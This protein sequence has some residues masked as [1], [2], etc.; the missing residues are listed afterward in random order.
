M[1]AP[2]VIVA[3]LMTALLLGGCAT[4]RAERRSPQPASELQP[5]VLALF[6]QAQVVLEER[7]TLGEPDD[8]ADRAAAL[9]EQAITLEPDSATL[10]RYLAGAWA[11]KPDHERAIVAATEAVALDPTDARAHHLLGT[12]LHLARMPALAEVHLREAAACGVGG[13]AP[14]DPHRRL[15][16]VL[17]E[18]GHDDEAV[19]ACDAWMVALPEDARPASLKAAFLWELGRADE[20]R[21]SAVAALLSDPRSDEARRIL[22]D[23]HR[24]DPTGEAEALEQALERHWSARGLHQRLS[25]VY[26]VMGRFDR[27]LDHLRYVGMLDQDSG[28]PLRRR[29]TLLSRMRRHAEATELLEEALKEG[30]DPALQLA[31]ADVR[32]AAGDP[33]AALAELGRVGPEDPAYWKAAWR[34][35][36]IHLD[37]AELDRAGEAVHAA[38]Q[39][40]PPEE[41]AGRAALLALGIEAEIEEGDFR[42]ADLM[43]T[44]LRRSDVE[45]AHRLRRLSLQRQGSL[46]EAIAL[47][48][49]AVEQR[50]SKLDHRIQLAGLQAEAGEVERAI[51]AFDAGLEVIQVR[52]DVQLGEAGRGQ[53]FAIA[54]QARGDTAW[55][56]LRRSFVEKDAGLGDRSEASLRQV[57]A[58]YP[59]NAEAL[60]ALA[61]L[62]AEEE[63]NL[64]EA[65]GL[66]RQALE[67][68][69]WSAAFLDTLGWV[70][71]RQGHLEEA[72]EALE[73]ADAWMPGDP[74]V[75]GHVQEVRQAL[76]RAVESP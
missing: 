62:W 4:L 57:L 16:R 54:E 22:T 73:T 36:R 49:E 53:A 34:R 52:R 11:R 33:D 75:L 38:R 66:V 64:E 63:R 55:L 10:H 13:D 8:R 7:Y 69:P 12:E 29:A 24:F 2:R 48:E 68:R 47:E 65:E 46:L 19:A 74:E 61:Y 76:G 9:L 35:A 15:F 40:V 21:E 44:E 27:A 14:A 32:E 31:L 17:Q 67:Q 28:D 39:L 30:D 20:A 1:L 59:H 50:P 51:A 43:L 37:R 72:L 5:P 60:N 23:Y 71:Y 18:L 42:Q 70:R 58:L 26:Q 6:L 56:L 3:G 41:Q 45:E 25:E